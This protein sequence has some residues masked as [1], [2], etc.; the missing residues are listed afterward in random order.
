MRKILFFTLLFAILIPCAVM[1]EGATLNCSYI[2]NDI[3]HIGVTLDAPK[4]DAGFYIAVYTADGTLNNMRK[5]SVD[6]GVYNIDVSV[7]EFECETD[8]TVKLFY[9][10][11]NLAP[12]ADAVICSKNNT[13]QFEGSLPDG[14]ENITPSQNRITYRTDGA[15]LTA[16]AYS[17]TGEDYGAGNEADMYLIGNFGYGT[18]WDDAI[19]NDK[20]R[21]FRHNIADIGDY[22]GRII[23]LYVDETSSDKSALSGV[24]EHLNN[25][26]VQ[27]E[28]KNVKSIDDS[29]IT[30]FVSEGSSDVATLIYENPVVII[31]GETADVSALQTLGEDAVFTV[32]EGTGDKYY[33]VIVAK[34]FVNDA[35]MT[36]EEIIEANQ[37]TLKY[38]KAVYSDI[39]SVRFRGTTKQIVDIVKGCVADA[40]AVGESGTQLISKDFVYEEYADRIAKAKEI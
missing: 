35:P 17:D 19:K 26:I 2:E 33:D 14:D 38:L 29:G 28:K 31:N 40:I 25:S 34:A 3:M 16:F 32:V 13:Q 9:L 18:Y 30:Y 20:F 22:C 39:T 6:G 15:F 8:E 4:E 11:K 24:S 21:V 37:E 12:L 7:S 1:A 36:K 27:L 23:R 5:C 10:D